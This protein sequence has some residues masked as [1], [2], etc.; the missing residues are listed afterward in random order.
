MMKKYIIIGLISLSLVTAAQEKASVEKN[1][2]GAQ[3]GLGN[4]SFYYETKLDR[5]ITLRTELGLELISSVK[6]DND[7]E[8]K[9][10]KATLI[11]PYL[12]LEP[13]FYYGLDRRN[14][15]ERSIKNN[16]SNYISLLTYYVSNR[17]PLMNTGDF[18]VVSSFSIIPK[19]GIRRA[20]AKHF[21]YEFSFG[22]GYKYN[23]FSNEKGCHC[24]HNN[25][26][27]DI[28]ARIGYDF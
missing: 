1:L 24:E 20:F 6:E 25:L 19:Y 5:K 7:P 16:S 3:L 18:D 14:K 27:F 10:E 11:S 21:N 17:T 13:R 23:I 28:Q 22:A 12:S 26:V 9:D 2:F 15:L 8:L 4:T